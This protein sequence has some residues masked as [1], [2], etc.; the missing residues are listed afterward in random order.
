MAFEHKVAARVFSTVI[1]FF[2]AV[3]FVTIGGGIEANADENLPAVDGLNGKITYTNSIDGSDISMFSGSIA[4]P[5][6][7]SFGLQIDGAFMP[8]ISVE[9]LGDSSLY[10]VGAHAFWRDPNRGLLGLVGHISHADFLDGIQFYTA[11]VESEKYWDQLS[12]ENFVGF[13]KVDF[14]DADFLSRSTLAY[15]PI[16]NLQFYVGHFH[17]HGFH[18]LRLGSEWSLGSRAG[19][20]PAIYADAAIIEGGHTSI[21]AGARVYFGQSDKSLIRR[22]RE[23]DPINLASWLD[24]VWYDLGMTNYPSPAGY[25][26]NLPIAGHLR[27]E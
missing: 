27:D 1:G 21:T 10:G 12:L 13:T 5:L 25:F 8:D 24:A 11:A 16:D 15:Y 22:H 6:G 3:G 7:H 18:G 17:A 9:G 20:T 26:R 2:A 14:R 23:D 4:V 19:A